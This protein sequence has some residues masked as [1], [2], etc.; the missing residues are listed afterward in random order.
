MNI[1]RQA[2]Q[3]SSGVGIRS[4]SEASCPP[5]GGTEAA[6]SGGVAGNTGG[7]EQ[8]HGAERRASVTLLASVTQY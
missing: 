6:S 1:N 5:S 7:Q 8:G 3:S 2:D 4:C